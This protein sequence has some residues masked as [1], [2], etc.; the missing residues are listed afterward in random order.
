MAKASGVV[1]VESAVKPNYDSRTI[2]PESF[3]PNK[4]GMVFRP[5]D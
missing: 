5:L 4:E 1:A 3:D 2:F